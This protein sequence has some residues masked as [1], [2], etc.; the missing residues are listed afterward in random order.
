MSVMALLS[1]ACL[2][3]GA[4]VALLGYDAKRRQRQ[5]M[6]AHVNALLELRE[7]HAPDLIAV[8]REGMGGSAG[9]A[10]GP[11]W[12]RHAGTWRWIGITVLL[13]C[14]AALPWGLLGWVR[15]GLLVWS[16]LV[17]VGMLVA[18]RRWQKLRSR[19]RRQLPTFIDNM[20]RMVVLGHAVQSA[21]LF[22]A[23]T[24]RMPLQDTLRQ[25]AAFARA[26]MPVD[27]ALAAASRHW[28]LD[29]FFLLT[30]IM[31]VGSRFGGRIDSLLERVSYFMRDREQAQQELYALSTEVRLSAWVLGLLPLVIGCMVIVTNA[32][33]FFQM[34]MDPSGR[35]LLFLAL[36][37]QAT[38]GVLLYRL[39]QLD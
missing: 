5:A 30:S 27:Q 28:N 4:G 25:A 13:A 6:V 14:A 37:L 12:M 33:Y 9:L 7:D 26:G 23:E 32:N 17:A 11:L 19:I 20:V 35:H 8:P 31:Q 16:A 22:S 2:A 34:W 39:A 21:F 36:G 1:S 18:W 3:A 38:G 10:W 29:E 24:A 15:T